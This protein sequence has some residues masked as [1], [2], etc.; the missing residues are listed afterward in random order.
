MVEEQK[1]DQK[2][3]C[4]GFHRA[5]HCRASGREV[6]L[7]DLEDSSGG[8]EGDSARNEPARRNYVRCQIAQ[9]EKL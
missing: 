2:T 6:N 4:W 7:E 1:K 3:W 9:L 8:A 5:Q